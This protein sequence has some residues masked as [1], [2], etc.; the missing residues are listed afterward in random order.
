MAATI[1]ASSLTSS[2]GTM[3]LFVC[4]QL[5][6]E[7]GLRAVAATFQPRAANNFAVARTMPDEV[8]V[9]RTDFPMV[10]PF[11]A[12]EAITAAKRVYHS[13]LL[14]PHSMPI[15]ATDRKA[16]IQI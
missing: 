14:A 11:F 6:K 7:A 8:P 12:F 4:S 5:A 9:T 15:G 13:T 3:M 2:F 16:F 10:L 1:V